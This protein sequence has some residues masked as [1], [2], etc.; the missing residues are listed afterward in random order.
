MA[1]YRHIDGQCSWNLRA[2]V[3][4]WATSDVTLP[5]AATVLFILLGCAPELRKILDDERAPMYTPSN[6]RC[7]TRQHRSSFHRS[8]NEMK[9]CASLHT[10]ASQLPFCWYVI[11]QPW[12]RLSRS[13]CCAYVRN[14]DTAEAAPFIPTY[15]EEGNM[16]QVQLITVL[17]TK[18]TI[19]ASRSSIAHLLS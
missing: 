15:R 3:Q 17:T 12:K 6:V 16:I 7:E 9:N 1:G 18:C 5:C 11:E 14:Y 2:N 13:P 19:G 8:R 10:R 4:L